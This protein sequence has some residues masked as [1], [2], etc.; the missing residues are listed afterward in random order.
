VALRSGLG[1]PGRVRLF[2][3][4][5]IVADSIPAAELE[6]TNVKLLTLLDVLD[7]AGSHSAD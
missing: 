2:A 4:A 5:G 7:D 1:G 3:G 6:E